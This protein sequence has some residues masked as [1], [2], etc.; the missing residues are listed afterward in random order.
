MKNILANLLRILLSTFFAMLL[1]MTFSNLTRN[2]FN[3]FTT[4]TTL[5]YACICIIIIAV[6]TKLIFSCLHFSF[7]DKKT[8]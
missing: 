1:I 2:S 3:S 5:L 4:V 7:E 6:I 8:R